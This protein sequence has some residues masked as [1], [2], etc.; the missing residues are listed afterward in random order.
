M[1]TGRRFRQGSSTR[2]AASKTTPYVVKL[3]FVEATSAFINAPGQ[4][5][6]NVLINGTQVLTELD[7]FAE[8]GGRDRAL[9]KSLSVTVQ[10]SPLVVQLAVGSIQNPKLN[11]IEVLAAN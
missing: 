4:R 3:H 8:A 1:P 7:I 9:V 2:L 5:R 6:F 11:A 10:G